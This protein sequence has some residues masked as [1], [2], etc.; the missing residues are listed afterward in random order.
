MPCFRLVTP[1]SSSCQPRLGVFYGWSVPHPLT[2]HLSF[3]FSSL[4]SPRPGVGI[5]LCLLSVLSASLVEFRRKAVMATEEGAFDLLVG[6]ATHR[7][8]TVSCLSLLPQFVFVGLAESFVRVA[9]E[10]DRLATRRRR[11]SSRILGNSGLESR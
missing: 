1:P 4:P 11:D 5:A 6:N 3:P 10:G 7:A 9:G 2:K 8:S